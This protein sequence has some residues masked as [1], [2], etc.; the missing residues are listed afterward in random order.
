M[1]G[2]TLAL[3]KTKEEYIFQEEE[4]GTLSLGRMEWLDPSL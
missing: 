1:E 4:V 3:N 2:F